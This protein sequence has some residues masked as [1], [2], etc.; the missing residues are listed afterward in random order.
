MAE[1]WQVVEIAAADTHPVRLVVLR[2][3]TPTKDVRFAEDEL[4]GAAHLGVFDGGRLVGVSSWIPRG[5]LEQP[6]VT[7]MQLRGMATLVEYQGRGVGTALLRSGVDRAAAQHIDV[8]WANARDS[9]L[10]FYLGHGFVVIGEGFIDATTALPHH[11]VVC[12]GSSA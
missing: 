6:D 11:R 5:L 8:V 2:A 1:R 10:P 12:T 4:E 3:H 9:A 7:A